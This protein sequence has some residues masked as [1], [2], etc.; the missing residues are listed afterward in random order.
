[1]RTVLGCLGPLL[2]LWAPLQGTERPN[3]VL[4]ITDDQGYG[5][6]AAHGNPVVRTPSMDQLHRT[7]V[8]FTDFHVDPTCSPTRAALMT[9]KY[10]HRARVWHTISGGNHLRETEVTLAD[11]FKAS[12]YRTALFGKW[13]L[14]NNYPYRPMDRG[15]DEWLGQGDGGTGT[16]DDAFYNDRVDDVFYHNGRRERRE[17][18]GP[19]VLFGAAI[20]YIRSYEREDPFFV[21]LATYVPHSPHAIPDKTWAAR[22]RERGVGVAEAYFFA[23][24]ERI[25]RDIGLLRACLEEKGIADDTVF[26]FMTDNGGTVG[27]SLFNAGM[28]GRKGSPYDGGHRVPCY[29]HWPGGGLDRPVDVPQLTAHIDLLPTLVD[30]CELTPPRSVD[31]DG[32]SLVPL[33]RGDEEAWPGRTLC[34]EVQR[35]L[36]PQK[37]R[38]CSVMTQ[39]WRLVNGTELYDMSSDPGQTRDVSAGHP[40]VVQSLRADFE[41]YW[42]RVSPGD[43]ERPRPI[44]GTTHQ[45]ET[46]LHS[47]E[48]RERTQWNH[49]QVATGA[50]AEGGWAIRVAADGRYVFE[51]R[52]WP[53]EA[54]A[55]LRGVPRGKGT[56]DAWVHDAPVSQLLYG[57][58]LTAV[59]VAFVRLTIGTYSETRPVGEDDVSVTFTVNLKAGDAEVTATMLDSERKEIGSAYYVYVKR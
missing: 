40:D 38:A 7:S 11:V 39:R 22:Y 3:V 27:C 59:P 44:V 58:R 33:M 9:G 37:G 15:F 43:R 8:R 21:Y 30:L 13:H 57:N 10:S 20:E 17:G 16:T 14:G 31:L 28:R 29:L 5:D 4:V 42:R 51:V 24:I 19:D 35:T 12:G 49:A 2:L 45:E 26:I 48:L 54:D 41:A 50:R 6:V 18:W 46:Y 34:V 23:S 52:R 55:P 32:R 1:M 36:V 56:V 53:R 47:S 25:D